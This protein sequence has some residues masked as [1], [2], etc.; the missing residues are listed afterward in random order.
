M[1]AEQLPSTGAITVR[2]GVHHRP[3]MLDSVTIV[4]TSMPPGH[5]GLYDVVTNT[6]WL[7]RRLTRAE[8]RCTI[9]HE[10]IHAERRDVRLDNRY[11]SAKQERLV[12]REASQRLIELQDLAEA[13][14]WTT[15]AS[16]LAECLDVDLVTLQTRLDA[17]SHAERALLE[18][19]AAARG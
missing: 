9:A 3:I 13:I 6:I 8:R 19:I 10:L 7:D 17:L 2:P 15:E 12:H 4:T 18:Q 1:A 16:E 14:R 11:L 5:R